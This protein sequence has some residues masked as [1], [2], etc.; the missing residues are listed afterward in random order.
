MMKTLIFAAASFVAAGAV[1]QTTPT[2]SSQPEKDARGIP[3]I[4]SPATAPAG[5]NVPVSAPAGVK[6]VVNA[7]QEAA[8]T[9][10]PAV[11]E[12]PACSKTVTDRCKQTYER[13]TR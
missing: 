9:A 10:A 2:A 4:S 1:A 5:T 6:V 3:V 13:G 7:N 12:M 11:G 8:F